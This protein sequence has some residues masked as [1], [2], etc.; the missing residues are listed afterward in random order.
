MNGQRNAYTIATLHSMA[1]QA[2]LHTNPDAFLCSDSAR[3]TQMDWE[4]YKQELGREGDD[5]PT[6]ARI[7]QT[8]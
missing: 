6:L 5:V 2:A 7:E 4:Y 3:C 8:F 1:Y